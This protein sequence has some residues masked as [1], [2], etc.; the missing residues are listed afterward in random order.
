MSVYLVQIGLWIGVFTQ[1]DFSAGHTRHESNL[2]ANPIFLANIMF[3]LGVFGLVGILFT[4]FTI[5]MI[6]L[7]LRKQPMH[8]IRVTL[9]L[10]MGFVYSLSLKILGEAILLIISL[11]I[12]IFCYLYHPISTEYLPE[13]VWY[14]LAFY[15][16]ELVVVPVFVTM[17][18]IDRRRKIVRM[19]DLGEA[20]MALSNPLDTPLMTGDGEGESS[21]WLIGDSEDS[22][23]SG[24]AT[25]AYLS[26][27]KEYIALGLQAEDLQTNVRGE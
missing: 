21:G 11:G 5:V 4:I 8:L 25:P 20:M 19:L 10:S 22:L 9:S 24:S 15:I 12:K 2:E 7:L 16:T 26:V 13:P 6:V 27:E 18:I 17:E 1:I 14:V 23:H 3:I